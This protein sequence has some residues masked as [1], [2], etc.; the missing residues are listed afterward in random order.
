MQRV[1]SDS[2][3]AGRRASGS[4]RQ[5]G[6]PRRLAN[7]G[8]QHTPHRG[9]KPCD[10]PG[11]Q[12]SFAHAPARLLPSI[13]PSYPVRKRRMT[14][15]CLFL[16]LQLGTASGSFLACKAATSQAQGGSCADGDGSGCGWACRFIFEDGESRD[17]CTAS[18]NSRWENGLYHGSERV[19]CRDTCAAWGNSPSPPSPLPVSL[20]P[21]SPPAPPKCIMSALGFEICPKAQSPPPPPASFVTHLW[22]SPSVNLSDSVACLCANQKECAREVVHVTKGANSMCVVCSQ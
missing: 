20:P 19:G 22:C 17:E 8:P 1:L 11:V 9:R 2:F 14:T 15:A 16:V 21:S 18:C 4:S 10:R 6:A 5:N 13:S 7:G 3:A 12:H